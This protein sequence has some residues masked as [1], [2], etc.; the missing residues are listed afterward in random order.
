MQARDHFNGIT[1]GISE[2]DAA[3]NVFVDM[4]HLLNDSARQRALWDSSN[5]GRALLRHLQD[6]A[7]EVAKSVPSQVLVDFMFITA[8]LA[9]SDVREAV[10][11]AMIEKCNAFDA[12]ELAKCTKLL[13]LRNRKNKDEAFPTNRLKGTEGAIVH[14]DQP[15]AKCEH[16]LVGKNASPQNNAAHMSARR[17]AIPAVHPK[18]VKLYEQKKA[19]SV[20]KRI[21]TYPHQAGGFNERQWKA[22]DSEAL[23]CAGLMDI[24]D[25]SESVRGL[26]RIEEARESKL[27][28]ALAD[29]V[30]WH[31]S[32]MRSREVMVCVN[33]FSK[34][35]HYRFPATWKTLENA[36]IRFS[37]QMNAHEIAICVNGFSKQS[38]KREDLWPVLADATVRCAAK[39]NPQNVANCV[40]G[41]SKKAIKRNDLWEAL[42]AATIR[43][44][45]EMDSQAIANSINGFSKAGTKDARLWKVLESGFLRHCERMPPL[46]IIQC[47]D[48]FSQVR[49]LNQDVWHHLGVAVIRCSHQLSANH[50]A[51]CI[52]R[53][54]LRRFQ[55]V[56][57]WQTLT[58][59]FLRTCREMDSKHLTMSLAG[60]GFLYGIG[61]ADIWK[62]VGARIVDETF[63]SQLNN[64][65]AVTA[66]VHTFN[67]MG[68][69]VV[70]W[71]I[72]CKQ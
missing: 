57:L 9:S 36:A 45:S 40:N 69:V 26:S 37:S 65:A 72:Q 39:M 48:G 53:F 47:V 51:V 50:T 2:G 63:A 1:K 5:E 66:F 17:P 32:Q 34:L 56:G 42:V 55:D 18:A 33:G 67:N 25:I 59:A 30:V 16:E 68:H 64:P 62:A 44:G 71:D 15:I 13:S 61:Q 28:N 24:V 35:D 70:F 23:Q 43:T 41:F 46:H 20:A 6:T 12:A 10:E 4:A 38:L 3:I 14:L 58:Q 54:S 7:V 60:M 11:A 27:W 31:A 52:H 19:K 22:L 21:F 29:G 49:C 8:F